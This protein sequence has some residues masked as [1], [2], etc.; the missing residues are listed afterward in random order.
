MSMLRINSEIEYYCRLELQRNVTHVQV[1]LRIAFVLSRGFGYKVFI[2]RHYSLDK[3]YY[4]LFIKI[5]IHLRLFKV[6]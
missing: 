6:N 4:F 1:E 3:I 5:M 2:L